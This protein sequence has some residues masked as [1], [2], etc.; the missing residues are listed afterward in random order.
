MSVIDDQL[1]ELDQSFTNWHLVERAERANN[2]DK[3][4]VLKKMMEMRRNGEP[5]P[6]PPTGSKWFRRPK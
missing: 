3:Y 6:Q 2:Y 1:T 5:L 4:P